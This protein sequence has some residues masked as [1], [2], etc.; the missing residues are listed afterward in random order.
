M[1]DVRNANKDVIA[2][3][4]F[5]KSFNTVIQ[6]TNREFNR[7]NR[8][9]G[10][11]GLRQDTQATYARTGEGLRGVIREHEEAASEGYKALSPVGFLRFL[12][13]VFT[14]TP[15]EKLIDSRTPLAEKFAIID[16]EIQRL[17]EKRQTDGVR[18]QI[19]QLQILRDRYGKQGQWQEHQ[20]RASLP[21]RYHE[22]LRVMNRFSDYDSIRDY[23]MPAQT[24]EWMKLYLE[25]GTKNHQR[26][27]P[28]DKNLLMY[29][30]DSR[31]TPGFQR[32][33]QAMASG[34]TR[35]YNDW[36]TAQEGA[37]GKRGGPE[38]GRDI[39]HLSARELSTYLDS[40]DPRYGRLATHY[41]NQLN[42]LSRNNLH[43]DPDEI[44]RAS[45]HAVRAQEGL[46]NTGINSNNINTL[47]RYNGTG[48]YFD[49]PATLTD[50][51]RV[52][53][54]IGIK[55]NC[56]NLQIG[57]IVG[58]QFYDSTNI[59]TQLNWRIPLSYQFQQR[60]STPRK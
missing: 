36:V 55:P 21:S 54:R 15:R 8:M 29:L 10:D 34:K 31:D 12:R 51:G 4:L 43:V 20:E 53:I 14:D 46:L 5:G 40:T 16:A 3:A 6:D 37:R 49:V 42:N 47:K 22:A 28:R 19:T 50:G 9:V 45:K 25:G 13:E 1:K 39:S 26:Y 58:G 48:F 35:E 32:F 60:G 44:V 17:G 41:A 24:K 33:I 38:Y 2:N 59:P 7:Y 57:D 27:Q 52:L 56:S 11:N 18:A 30:W 23:R